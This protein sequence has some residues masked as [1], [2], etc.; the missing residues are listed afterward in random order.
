M[1]FLP[2][3][4]SFCLKTGQ[5]R[6]L[7]QWM[8]AVSGYGAVLN[9]FGVILEQF[10]L[11]LGILVSAWGFSSS[12]LF[13]PFGCVVMGSVL[14]RLLPFLLVCVWLGGLSNL[15]ALTR[16]DM[17]RWA[18][19]GNSTAKKGSLRSHGVSSLFFRADFPNHFYM[20]VGSATH[21]RPHE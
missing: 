17:T 21:G 18:F 9:Y 19:T 1:P 12:T 16:Q 4:H 10:A 7:N 14:G 20:L 8:C 15:N 6:R 13:R 5:N 11:L 2:I 3:K